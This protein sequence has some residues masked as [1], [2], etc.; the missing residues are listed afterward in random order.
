MSKDDDDSSPPDGADPAAPVDSLADTLA[1]SDEGGSTRDERSPSS[2]ASLGRRSGAAP[3]VAAPIVAAPIGA[4]RVASRYELLGLAGE[5]AHGTVFKAFDTL[6][7]SL[8][9][10]KLLKSRAPSAVLRAEIATL[11]A[12]DLPGVVRFLDD[13]DFDGSP[14]LVTEWVTGTPFPGPV[15]G[16]DQLEDRF[17]ALL[18]IVD[19]LHTVGV[20]HRDLK[21]A[22]ILVDANGLITVLDLGVAISEVAP[23]RRS[24]AGTPMYLA[25]EVLGSERPPSV[26]SDLYALGVTLAEALGCGTLFNATTV[27]ELYA[28]KQRLPKLSP[29]IAVPGEVEELLGTLLAPSAAARPDSCAAVV[30]ALVRTRELTGWTQRLSAGDVPLTEEQLQPLFHGPERVLHLPTLGARALFARTDGDRVAV[31]QEVAAWVRAGIASWDG[32]QLRTCRPELDRLDVSPEVLTLRA[33]GSLRETHEES[34]RG[35]ARAL[36]DAAER[37]RHAGR[38]GAATALAGAAWTAAR[39]VGDFD[40]LD[41]VALVIGRCGTQFEDRHALDVGIAQLEALETDAAD[42][43]ARLLRCLRTTLRGD[44]VDRMLD[45]YSRI[46]PFADRVLERGRALARSRIAY[47]EPRDVCERIHD[48]LLS[49]ATARR[50]DGLA[51]D[52]RG[53]SAHL[54]YLRGDFD[55]CARLR[56]Q[57]ADRTEYPLARLG[58]LANAA[59]A[60]VELDRSE[61][62]VAIADAVVRRAAELQ[63]PTLELQA[64]DRLRDVRYRRKDPIEMAPELQAAARLSTRRALAA[65]LFLTEAAIG[66]RRGEIDCALALANDALRAFIETQNAAGAFLTR[67][68]IALLESA[69]DEAAALSVELDEVRLPPNVESQCRRLVAAAAHRRPPAAPNGSGRRREILADDELLAE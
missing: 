27:G 42:N 14:F 62:A 39:G 51:A 43:I 8:V 48:T 13:G 5:G 20:L 54:H 56:L 40:L 30:R 10:V 12:L 58:F 55:T 38:I 49:Q 34:A 22:N 63:S 28:E 4:V 7:E 25:P 15:E 52:V 53:W 32:D 9:A 2:Q 66:W 36:I 33:T 6:T 68:F 61:E 18:E 29:T 17:V 24:L 47:R 31:E 26:Q 41:D 69:D 3:I 1:A 35:R 37:R 60:M 16:W 19:R 21:P 50:D 64:W 46:E 65:T 23:D 57:A 67:C 44:T 45:E 11:R 59:A